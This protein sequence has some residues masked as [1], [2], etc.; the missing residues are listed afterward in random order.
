MTETDQFV[1]V[2][3]FFS[4]KLTLKDQITEYA[5]KSAEQY[6]CYV[7]DIKVISRIEKI[8]L[9]VSRQDLKALSMT[10]CA[11]IN[12]DFCK[13]LD[14]YLPKVREKFNIEVSSA[15]LD[16]SLK[17]YNEFK[18]AIGARVSITY[19]FNDQQNHDFCIISD[20]D[21][22]SIELLKEHQIIKFLK[23]P[24]CLNALQIFAKSIQQKIEK[25]TDYMECVAILLK[26]LKTLETEGNDQNDLTVAFL[27]NPEYSALIKQFISPFRA[28]YDKILKVR[29]A[30]LL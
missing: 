6:D 16:R 13:L 2:H 29:L 24:T 21:N 25:K 20:S 8:Q 26:L 28:K 19:M 12:R 11:N 7:T 22:E 27:K 10:E 4:Q 14:I 18:H 9:F 5:N 15:G 1:P 17:T 30:P 23:N 3:Q